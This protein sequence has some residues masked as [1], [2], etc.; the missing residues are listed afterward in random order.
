MEYPKII[1]LEDK[2]L[3]KL[4]TEKAELIIKGRKK[5]EEIEELEKQMA[6]T[7]KKIQEYE[8]SVDISDLRTRGDEI[9]VKMQ[10]LID[11]MKAIEQDIYAR[12]KKD[13]PQALYD[14]YDGFKKAKEEAENERNK[15]ALKAQKYND[16]IIP[17]GRKLMKPYLKDEFDDYES[18]KIVGGKVIATIFNHLDEF[19]T[20]FRKK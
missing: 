18:L 19:K 6:V 14:E 9:A 3:K 16:K 17:L 7:D 5:S 15:I 1:K 4:L 11:E 8:K 12:M 10:G 2:K 13:A 20:N